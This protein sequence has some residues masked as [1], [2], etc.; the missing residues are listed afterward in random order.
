[1]LQ[2]RKTF[3]APLIPFQIARKGIN[4][5]VYIDD[6]KVCQTQKTFQRRA[7]RYALF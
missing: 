4:F 2:L 1:M 5:Y 7:L 6:K 3:T